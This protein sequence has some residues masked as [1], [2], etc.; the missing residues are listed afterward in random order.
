V[1]L[2]I[3]IDF[4]KSHIYKNV[5]KRFEL[6][7]HELGYGKKVHFNMILKTLCENIMDLD[8]ENGL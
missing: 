1:H 2:Y 8:S 5:F 4:S 7:G 3:Q 6:K